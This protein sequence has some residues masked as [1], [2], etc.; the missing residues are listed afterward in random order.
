MSEDKTGSNQL[1]LF[2]IQMAEPEELDNCYETNVLYY[3]ARLAVTGMLNRVRVQNLEFNTEKKRIVAEFNSLAR[4]TGYPQL[5][6][7]F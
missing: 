5:S 3:Q 6:I 7:D 2:P 1:L 4:E